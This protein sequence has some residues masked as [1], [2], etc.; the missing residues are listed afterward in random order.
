VDFTDRELW[1]NSLKSARQLRNAADYDTYPK[2]EN[3]WRTQALALEQ[4]AEDL[5][6]LSL[7][8]LRSKGC[9]YI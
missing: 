3:A 6:D 5:I 9:Q 4:Q 1:E 7:A 8:Y 2:S